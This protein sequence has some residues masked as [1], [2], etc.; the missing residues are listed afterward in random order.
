MIIK[1]SMALLIAVLVLPLAG[2]A[3]DKNKDTKKPETKPRLVP[4]GT[5]TAQVVEVDGDT[6]RLRLPQAGKPGYRAP[7]QE[8]KDGK[9]DA[10]LELPLVED[11]K[12]RVPYKPEL[13]D[14]GRPKPPPKKDPKDPDRNLPG[15]KGSTADLHK[16]V[17]VTV[18]LAQTRERQPKTMATLVIVVDEGGK[19]DKK[20]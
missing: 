3:D 11:V 20:K 15:V 18:T 9:D 5:V 2:V 12:I 7:R 14:K 4:A 19:G 10:D 8:G 1:R 17:W 13:D 6:L 16:G